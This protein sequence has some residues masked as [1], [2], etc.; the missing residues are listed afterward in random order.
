MVWESLFH[1]NSSKYE[2]KEVQ[3]IKAQGIQGL[4]ENEFNKTT[5]FYKILYSVVATTWSN[6]EEQL[7][8]G[9]LWRQIV[10]QITKH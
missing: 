8:S 6:M 3:A 9:D 5:E 10:F 4:R 1:T 7:H 2:Q